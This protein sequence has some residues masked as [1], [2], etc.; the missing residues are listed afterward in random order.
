MRVH[1]VQN[2]R[3]SLTSLYFGM[4]PPNEPCSL[5][6]LL[7]LRL[8]YFDPLHEVQTGLLASHAS[9]LTSLHVCTQPAFRSPRSPASHT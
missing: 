6:A 3:T 5:P 8:P 7:S 1:L 2:N 4:M 9:Q